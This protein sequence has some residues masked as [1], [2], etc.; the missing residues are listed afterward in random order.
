MA[1]RG[2]ISNNKARAGRLVGALFCCQEGRRLL[3]DARHAGIDLGNPRP[4]THSLQLNAKAKVLIQDVYA[5]CWQAQP[6][7]SVTSAYRRAGLI[8]RQLMETA[9]RQIW[10]EPIMN[11]KVSLAKQRTVP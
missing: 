9:S 7:Q 2:Q 11:N 1:L 8:A 5:L 10:E 6:S 3:E 4:G